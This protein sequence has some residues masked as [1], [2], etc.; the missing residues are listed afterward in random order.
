MKNEILNEIDTLS[1]PVPDGT[2]SGDPVMVGSFVGVAA[3][4]R[5]DSTVT[6]Y[7]LNRG[8]GNPD[9]YAS[10]V[11][12]NERAFLLDVEGAIAGPGTPVYITGAG[13]FV[14]STTNGGT[15]AVFGHT[16]PGPDNLYATKAAGTGP[17]AV[18]LAAV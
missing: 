7:P 6:T 11:I 12:D 13:P 2:K 5:A 1:L 18:K 10:V 8:G 17:A 16:I 3:T 15:D 14:L 4:D 9:G